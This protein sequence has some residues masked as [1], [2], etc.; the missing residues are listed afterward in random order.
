MAVSRATKEK[1]VAEL[2]AGF[3]ESGAL[4]L[5]DYRGVP[6]NKMTQLRFELNKL[7]AKMKI[8]KNRLALRVIDQELAG[9]ARKMLTDMTSVTLAKGDVAA[10]AK[11]LTKFAKENPSF[12]VKGGIFEGKLVS[13]S[14]VVAISEL[15][16]R[17]QL[18]GQLVSTWNAVPTGFVRVLNAVPGGFVNVLD[19]LKR[20]KE[21]EAS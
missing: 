13:P 9:E 11:A 20:K 21:T 2:N 14:E 8:V 4:F 7:E 12:V 15:P 16:S 19:A 5:T 1:Q 18:L 17:E 3:E 6:V 10:T